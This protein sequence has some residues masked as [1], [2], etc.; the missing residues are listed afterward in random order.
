MGVALIILVKCSI[1]FDAMNKLV[2][3]VVILVCGCVH[4]HAQPSAQI[5]FFEEDAK[6]KV[7]SLFPKFEMADQDGVIISNERFRGR[8]TIVRFFF[9]DCP[10]CRKEVKTLN[11]MA[12]RHRKQ[13]VRY[14]AF[15]FDPATT[16]HTYR[17]RTRSEYRLIPDAKSFAQQKVHLGVFPTH[18]VIDGEG[19]ISSVILGTGLWAHFRLEVALLMAQWKEKRRLRTLDDSEG[20]K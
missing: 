13:G 7:G 11:R 2:L 20:Q 14:L 16:L 8:I 12:K 19:R 5:A 17:Q 3:L 6:N 4:A 10:P 15:A 9:V 18:M 1:R